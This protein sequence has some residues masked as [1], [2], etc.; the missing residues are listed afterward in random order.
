[1]YYLCCGAARCRQGAVWACGCGTAGPAP[2]TS[3][4]KCL[5]LPQK[6]S[7]SEPFAWECQPARSPERSRQNA[8]AARQVHAPKRGWK[9]SRRREGKGKEGKKEPKPEHM[10]VLFIYSEPLTLPIILYITRCLGKSCSEAIFA[11]RENQACA[12][13]P[14]GEGVKHFVPCETRPAQIHEKI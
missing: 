13:A 5:F 12:F 9:A 8:G 3:P 6:R 14:L 7:L 10:C 11:T 2:E 1:M 4:Q